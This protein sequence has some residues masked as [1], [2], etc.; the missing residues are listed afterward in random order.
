MNR[1][2]RVRSER[3]QVATALV[4]ILC[5][6]LV[7]VGLIGVFALSRGADEKSKAQSAADAAALAGAASFEDLVPNII[8]LI[9]SRRGLDGAFGCGLGRGDAEDF[10]GRNDAVLTEYCFDARDD[11]VRVAVRMNDPVTQDVGPAEATAEASTGLGLGDCDWKDEEPPTPT[12]SS[13]SSSSPTAT[14]S[15]PTTPPPPPDFTSTL[16]CGGFRA[17]F[18]VDGETGRLQLSHIDLDTLKP[19]LKR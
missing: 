10:A 2:A 15:T 9:H 11:R 18:E 7:A 19:R 13:S 3:G 17:E 16:T 1:T 5:V 4:M 8:G 14:P 6:G 12:P